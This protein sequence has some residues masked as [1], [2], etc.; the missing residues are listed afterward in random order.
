MSGQDGDGIGQS[1]LK[2]IVWQ[3]RFWRSRRA[4]IPW[5]RPTA[6]DERR[7]A[8]FPALGRFGDFTIAAADFELKHWVVRERAWSGWPDPPT[9][10]VFALKDET[11][12]MARDFEDW[13]PGWRK[14]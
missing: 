5:Q 7:F 1:L 3:W 14:P 11:V 4:D 9:F 12:W 6:Q 8:A 13:P 2:D 10:V